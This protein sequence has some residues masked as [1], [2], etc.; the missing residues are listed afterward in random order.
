M[1]YEISRDSP[2]KKGS[3]KA[4]AGDKSNEVEILPI[5]SFIAL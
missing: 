3:P 1:K 4:F 5:E 2:N